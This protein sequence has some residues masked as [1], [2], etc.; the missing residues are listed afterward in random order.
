MATHRTELHL[1][2]DEHQTGTARNWMSFVN[3]RVDADYVV[4]NKIRSRIAIINK[5]D[6]E[7]I[8]RWWNYLPSNMID[9]SDKHLFDH[10]HS[11]LYD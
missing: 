6:C 7:I 2:L 4:L 3:D 9:D 10:I 11:F 8:V 5:R 1:R